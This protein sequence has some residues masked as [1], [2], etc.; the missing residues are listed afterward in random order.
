[1][2]RE[3]RRGKGRLGTEA[4][5]IPTKRSYAAGLRSSKEPSSLSGVWHFW[6]YILSKIPSSS[7]DFERKDVG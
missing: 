2:G 5:R 3:A 7:S 1:M 6:Q 4:R